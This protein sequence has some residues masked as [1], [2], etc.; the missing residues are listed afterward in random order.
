M[1]RKGQADLPLH[2]GKVPSWLYER[3]A[4]MAR[5]ITEAILS[6]YGKDE[7]L[8][9]ISDPFWF[10]SLGAVLGMDWHSSGITTSVIGALKQ[11]INPLSKEMGLYVCGG[12][13]SYSRKTP[14]ELMRYSDLTGLNGNELVRTSRLTAKIDNTAIQDGFQ[15]YLH[16]FIISDSGRWSVVQQGMNASTRYARRYHYPVDRANYDHSIANSEQALC[17]ARVGDREKLFALRRLASW[18][19]QTRPTP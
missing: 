18:G 5:A 8:R 15:I 6:D 10:Q 11:A 19:E 7:F 2:P 13:G 14:D 9:R 4:G 3:M 17:R 12:R 16:S 1:I